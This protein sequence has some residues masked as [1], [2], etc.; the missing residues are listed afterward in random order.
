MKRKKNQILIFLI[1][2]YNKINFQVAIKI[3][4]RN[5]FAYVNLCVYFNN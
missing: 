5:V 4:S 1:F 3:Y 2:E